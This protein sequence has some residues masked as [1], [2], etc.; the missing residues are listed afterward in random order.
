MALLSSIITHAGTHPF[1]LLIIINCL[2]FTARC[3]YGI[4]LHPISHI[5]GPLLAKISS[6][7]LYYH[8]YIGDEASVIHA[9]H[10]VFGDLVRVSPSQIDIAD[11]DA[12]QGIYISGGGFPKPPCYANFDI[13]GHPTIFST[14]SASDRS[15]RARAV[16]AMFSTT[17]IRANSAALYGCVDRMIARL[18]V[19]AATGHAVNVLNLTRALAIDTVSTHLFQLDYGGLNEKSGG[20]SVSA[21]VNAFV[22]VGRFFYLPTW[23]FLW[24]DW[25]TT[26]A[27]SDNH[28]ETSM[29]V[30][31]KF[32]DGLVDARRKEETNFPGRLLAAGF[33][34]AEVVAQCKDLIFAGTDSTGMNL[35]IICRQMALNQDK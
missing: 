18:E 35:A 14:T 9:L 16:V 21:F 3:I 12:I 29:M 8:S 13:D 19:E 32:V 25:V 2:L 23:A 11:A 30:V 6:L 1:S 34:R 27:V 22:A 15:P 10:D 5:P 24:L 28:T 4:Y 20:L 31:D 7:W 33:E 26:K 17:A